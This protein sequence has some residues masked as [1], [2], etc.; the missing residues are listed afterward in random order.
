MVHSVHEDKNFMSVVES[1]L[2]AVLTSSPDHKSCRGGDGCSGGGGDGGC[3]DGGCGC[4][5]G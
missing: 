1:L 4:G 2:N 5:Q 3:G